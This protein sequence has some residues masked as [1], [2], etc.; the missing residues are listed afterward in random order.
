MGL[1]PEDRKIQGLCLGQSI[2]SNTAIGLF[3][4]F[5]RFGFL[6]N[7]RI[8]KIVKEFVDRLNVRTPGILQLVR[9]L[10]GGNQQKVVIARWLTLNPKILILDEPTR[11]VDVAAKAEIHALMSELAGQGVAVLMVSSEL[12][13]ILGVCDRILVMREGRIVKEFSRTEATQDLIMQAATG[14]M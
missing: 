5:T 1:I 3:N 8:N 9:N 14:Q 6:D 2:R 11:G 7:R 12:P 13:E 4:L 10:S